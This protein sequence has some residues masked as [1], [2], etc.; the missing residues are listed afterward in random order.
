MTK[1]WSSLHTACNLWTH[2][3][4]LPLSHDQLTTSTIWLPRDKFYS[5]HPVF[6]TC[7]CS[8][9]ICIFNFSLTS[10]CFKCFRE[11]WEV[12]RCWWISFCSWIHSSHF[13]PLQ[14]LGMFISNKLNA[15]CE[16]S[17]KS[18]IQQSCTKD[19]YTST[20]KWSH[21]RHNSRGALNI[22]ELD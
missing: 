4:K 19:W 6:S 8:C 22:P 12:W 10:A 17:K 3:R 11:R 16:L 1:H 2:K 9:Q 5:I 21:W 15:A 14:W 20:G 7:S 18:P 13:F